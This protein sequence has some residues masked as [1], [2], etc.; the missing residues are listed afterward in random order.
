VR[1]LII[2][3]RIE[4]ETRNF[5]AAINPD[6]QPERAQSPVGV[7]V[8]LAVT[9]EP[10]VVLLTDPQDGI[11]HRAVERNPHHAPVSVA[12]EH[13]S[14]PKMAG[15]KSGVGIVG[16]HDRAV[17][18]RDATKCARRLGPPRP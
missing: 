7:N 12:S 11:N 9:I 16:E 18:G 4:P 6:A 2:G 17:F 14:W 8:E 15:I 5:R 3:E 13:H 1:Y 10:R